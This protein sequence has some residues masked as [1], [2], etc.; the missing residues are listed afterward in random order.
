[1]VDVAGKNVEISYLYVA[2]H[3]KVRVHIA[4]TGTLTCRLEPVVRG[5]KSTCLP[6]G[7]EVAN[8][9]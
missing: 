5:G 4:Y 8:V 6:P 1:M 9:I 3:A 7:F 2:G